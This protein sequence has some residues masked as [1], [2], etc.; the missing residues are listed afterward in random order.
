MPG[1]HVNSS[2][3]QPPSGKTVRLNSLAVIISA[4]S[5]VTEK[6]YLPLSVGVPLIAPVSRLSESPAGRDEPS[7][8]PHVAAISEL[9]DKLYEYSLPTVALSSLLCV[10]IAS[11]SLSFIL[12]MYV[13]LVMPLSFSA[14]RVKLIIPLSDGTP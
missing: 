14:Q 8:T 12:N 10:V 4:H 11:G 5:A 6:V 1:I 7:A 13:F 3:K 9:T 2:C